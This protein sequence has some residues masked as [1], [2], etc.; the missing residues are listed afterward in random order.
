MST[1]YV[2]NPVSGKS[3]AVGGK[4]YRDLVKAGKLENVPFKKTVKEPKKINSFS[5][6]KKEPKKKGFQPKSE[7]SESKPIKITKT[8]KFDPDTSGEDSEEIYKRYKAYRESE[9]HQQDESPKE[10]VK[11]PIRKNRF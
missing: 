10:S 1:K 3:I 5:E 6:V 2:L 9:K 11:K 4:T 8:K 7:K